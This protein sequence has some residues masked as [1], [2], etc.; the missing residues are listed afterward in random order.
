MTSVPSNGAPDTL[1]LAWKISGKWSLS[2]CPNHCGRR[3]PR[4]TSSCATPI[5][6]TVT[7]SRGALKNTRRKQNSTITPS[8]IAEPAP[9]A[10]D[11]QMFH[12]TDAHNNSAKPA[13]AAPSS[14]AAKFTMRLDRYTSTNASAIIASTSPWIAPSRYMPIGTVGHATLTPTTM[15]A[16]GAT[17][18]ID[19]R[20]ISSREVRF[21]GRPPAGRGST[22]RWS[23][24]HR[25]RRARCLPATSP[26]SAG[27]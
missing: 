24:R 8:K 13:G 17:A 26:T 7:M 5:V 23:R 3:K 22:R 21:I 25:R 2:G 1:K 16:S 19:L 11:S 6:A 4:A 9:T 18:H 15:N 14:A 10:N 27:S 12:P 20:A